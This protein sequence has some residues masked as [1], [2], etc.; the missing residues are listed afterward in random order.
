MVQ[1]CVS[2]PHSHSPVDVRRHH[3]LKL[4]RWRRWG[5]S[6]SCSA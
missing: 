6:A 4:P 3:S 1:A 5:W 2:P